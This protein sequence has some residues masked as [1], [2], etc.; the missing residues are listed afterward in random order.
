MNSSVQNTKVPC[1]FC[2]KECDSVLKVFSH[3]RSDHP[4]LTRQCDICARY[5]SSVIAM[6]KHRINHMYE[7][8]PSLGEI[9][10]FNRLNYKFQCLVC[11]RLILNEEALELHEKIHKAFLDFKHEVH[12]CSLCTK[13]FTRKRH[14][15]LHCS[16][17]HRNWCLE[18]KL[19]LNSPAELKVSC[20]SYVLNLTTILNK[21]L[22]V[23]V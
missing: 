10:T 9:F 8:D 7:V 6:V 2:M 13:Q 23:C 11:N 17:A 1:P 15:Q 22:V 19:D 12:K 18:C 4:G 14:L 21:F 20:Y 3:C 16:V 5:L